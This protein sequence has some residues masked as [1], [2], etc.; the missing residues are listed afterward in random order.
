[1]RT[2][3]CTLF[4]LVTTYESVSVLVRKKP[5]PGT[6]TTT[7]PATAANTASAS[8]SAAE[9]T[10]PDAE[11]P[12]APPEPVFAGSKQPPQCIRGN[13]GGMQVSY[14]VSR[15]LSGVPGLYGLVCLRGLRDLPVGVEMVIGLDPGKA[16]TFTSAS[17]R[18]TP[19]RPAVTSTRSSR[20]WKKAWPERFKKD[21]E[22]VAVA[23][24]RNGRCRLKRWGYISSGDQ[25]D[26]A[27]LS[28]CTPKGP[29]AHH[30][31]D[32][33]VQYCNVIMT[34]LSR[35]LSKEQGNARL[36]ASSVKR[37]FYS[38]AVRGLGVTRGMVVALGHG[39]LG[40]GGRGGGP[41]SPVMVRTVAVCTAACLCLCVCVSVCLC[42]CTVACLCLYCVVQS[43]CSVLVVGT[44]T[45]IHCTAV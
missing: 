17:G 26:E 2:D 39:F 7:V 32:A 19:P 44:T 5:K 18:A 23:G 35:R 6:A 43:S 31:V 3:G 36:H 24:T 37:A 25:A 42:V 22:P 41:S 33:L 12:P 30:A 20:V 21:T 16:K 10:P 8:A 1:M 15:F 34:Y 28:A 45:T 11:V 27:R 38:S 9:A 13:L 29:L 14:S 40:R 4:L